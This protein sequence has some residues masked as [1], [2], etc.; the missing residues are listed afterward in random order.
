[1]N[2]TIYS[3]KYPR[4]V[5]TRKMIKFF[6][7]SLLNML[8][9]VEIQHPERLP[10]SGPIILA[11][12]H[13][14]ATDAVMMAV[15]TPGI[16]EFIGTGDIPFD[17]NYSLIANTYGVIPINRGNLDRQSLYM[18]LDVLK[19]GG[20]LG[21]FPEGGIWDPAN[22]TPQIGVA[23]LSSQGE[24]PILPIGFGNMKDSLRKA[25]TFKHPK[26]VM[27]IGELMPPAGIQDASL[28]LKDNLK[29][30]AVEIFKAINALVPAVELKKANHRVDETYQLDI[31]VHAAQMSIQIPDPLFVQHGSAYAHFLFNPTMLDV[32]NR[33]LHLPLKPLKHVYR[34]TDL[35][36]VIEAW[37]SILN[38]LDQNPGY[39]TYRFGV[40]EGLAVKQA[41][42]ELI[43]MASWVD[44]SGYA[45]SINPIRRYR[46]SATNALVIEQGGCYPQSM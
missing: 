14:A 42:I 20:I 40:D 10:R 22:M 31:E 16:V 45:L 4:R 37:Q 12:N 21:I 29:Q 6:G 39:F 15:L 17:P 7:K 27:N 23:W 5:F 26:L 35:T 3:L 32:L 28:S 34:Q 13:A 41:L 11:G 1:M 24:T 8:A 9:E 38:Y 43:H 19:Q 36:P 33:N 44:Q 30:S 2:D 18:G 25:L 46:N